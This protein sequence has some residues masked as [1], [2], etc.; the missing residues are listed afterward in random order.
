MTQFIGEYFLETISLCDDIIKCYKNSKY[1]YQGETQ[2][3]YNPKIKSSTEATLDYKSITGDKYLKELQIALDKYIIEYPYCNY[4]HPF[5]VIENIKIQHYLPNQGYFD[6]HCE[7][8]GAV[9]PYQARH[10][11][12]MTYLNDVT[13]AGET[14]FYHQKLKVKPE[15]GKTLIWPADWT[16]THRG[17]TSSTEEKYI[18]TGWLSYTDKFIKKNI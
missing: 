17:I 6:Y 14:E 3:G 2:N 11:V 13:N 15:K 16:F 18:I 4:Y 8:I 10:L 7:R 1:K 9:D 12:F 5:A